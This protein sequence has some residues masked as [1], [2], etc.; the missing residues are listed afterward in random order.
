MAFNF[1]CFS[2]SYVHL[3]GL[4]LFLFFKSC[5]KRLGSTTHLSKNPNA[6]CCLPVVNG[7]A[8]IASWLIGGGSLVWVH[9]QHSS[10]G[11]AIVEKEERRGLLVES[12]T[13]TEEDFFSFNSG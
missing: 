6:V 3:Q 4:L 7:E 2:C 5:N 8:K 11:T 1:I 12:V 9:L 10:S 13:Q